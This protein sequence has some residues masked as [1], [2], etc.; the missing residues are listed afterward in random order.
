MACY[1]PLLFGQWVDPTTGVVTHGILSNYQAVERI[2]NPCGGNQVATYLVPCG[3]C[4]GC[5]A[6]RAHGWS[7]RLMMESLYQGSERT[8][9]VTL[10]YDD[11]HLPGRDRLVLDRETLQPCVT[12]CLDLDD[13]SSWIKRLRSALNQSGI[14]FYA[15]GEYGDN[16]RRPHY[17]VILFADIPDARSVKPV[18][19]EHI[20]LPKGRMWSPIVE[21]TWGKG[22]TDCS[23]A[24]QAAMSYVAGYVTKKLYGTHER[25]YQDAVDQ[26]KNLCP[27]ITPQPPECARMSRRPGLGVPWIREHVRECSYGTVA[28]PTPEGARR[29]PLPRV[30]QNHLPPDI[31]QNI[32]QKNQERILAHRERARQVLNGRRTL[33]DDLAAKE[34]ANLR[35]PRR[36]KRKQ[37][38]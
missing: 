26:F 29:A 32:K 21:Q 36:S 2:D 1:H 33:D 30:A 13:V 6:D 7:D 27:E 10:T 5:R 34:A 12:G 15:A 20:S 17:H 23:P 25:A 14:R 16:T 19:G 8:W 4:S 18:D 28:L 22:L 24:G 35:D 11:E 38:L 31:I 3:Q 37:S 9:C